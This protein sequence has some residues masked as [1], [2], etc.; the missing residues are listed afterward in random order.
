MKTNIMEFSSGNDHVEMLLLLNGIIEH[1]RYCRNQIQE[2]S[3]ISSISTQKEIRSSCRVH[4]CWYH[5]AEKFCVSADG[6]GHTP[7]MIRWSFFQKHDRGVYFTTSLPHLL[8]TQKSQNTF[9]ND[10]KAAFEKAWR[11]PHK[12][13][14]TSHVTLSIARQEQAR[15][16][17]GDH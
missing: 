12:S 14:T 7:A 3:E 16:A 10:P 9:Q 6:C 15:P 1:L 13:Q 17:V 2:I 4:L 11:C 5:F 8:Y